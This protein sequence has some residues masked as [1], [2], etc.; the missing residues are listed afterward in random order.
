MNTLVLALILACSTPPTVSSVDPNPAQPGI[1]VK[2]F[3]GGFEEGTTLSLAMAGGDPIPFEEV[4]V[5]GTVVLEAKLPSELSA[6]TYD[7]VFGAN[8]EATTVIGA[9]VVELP[10]LERPCSGE[11]TANTQVSLN[12]K[13]AVV[14]RFYKNGER[15][16]VRIDLGEIERI[17]F[18]N[19][20]GEKKICSVIWFATKDGNRVIFADDDKVDLK[21]RAFKL[22]RDMNKPIADITAVEQEKTPEE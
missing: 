22:S 11:Y 20:P 8:G 13:E 16:T 19:R 2:V 3:G 14:D 6:G 5:V 12:R 4:K 21:D 7:L 9:L 10:V 17:E 15:E 18:E 1:A